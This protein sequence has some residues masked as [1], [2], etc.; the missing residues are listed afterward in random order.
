MDIE[1]RENVFFSNYHFLDLGI[2]GN[3]GIIRTNSTVE[4]WSKTYFKL[5]Y[6]FAHLSYIDSLKQ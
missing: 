3:K 1:V 5:V 4:G 2:K 6:L